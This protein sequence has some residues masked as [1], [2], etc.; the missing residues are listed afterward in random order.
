MSAQTISIRSESKEDI[1]KIYLIHK[2]A[3]GQENESA[4][5]DA[6]RETSLYDPKLSLL[7]IIDE[8]PVGH[9]LFYPL[10][11]ET[12]NGFINTLGLVPLGVITE[13]QKQGVGTKLVEEGIKVAK[14]FG[15]TSV[16]VVGNPH[17]YQRFGFELVKGITNNIHEP[18]DRVMFLE[19]E[20]DSLKNVQGVLHY[21]KEFEGL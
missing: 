15:Y 13:F 18:N 12:T 16:F 9:I 17:Y 14:S 1:Q 4:L 21:P 20:K 2:Q 19:L 3:F 6:L 8:K 11:V 7:A 5:I 10:T